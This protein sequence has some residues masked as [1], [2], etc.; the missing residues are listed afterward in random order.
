MN[1]VCLAKFLSRLEKDKTKF[2]VNLRKK[3]PNFNNFLINYFDAFKSGKKTMKVKRF[4]EEIL[5]NFDNG[6]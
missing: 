5:R 2:F 1:F 3:F 6:I 4:E